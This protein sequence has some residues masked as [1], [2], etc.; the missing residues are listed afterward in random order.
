M[1]RLSSEERERLKKVLPFESHCTQVAG[2]GMHYFDEGQGSAVILLHGNPTWSFMFRA[3]I[4]GLRDSFRVIAPDCI[5]LGLSEHPREKRFRAIDRVTHLEEL[6]SSLSVGRFSL[7]MHDWG[8]SI[9]SMLAARDP[10]RVEKLVYLNTTLTE[11]ESL[12]EIIKQATT[13]VVGKIL[14]KY[15]TSFLRLLTEMG[16]A[17]RLSPEIRHAYLL[18]YPSAADRQAIWDF[19]ADIPFGSDH[20]SHGDLVLL[21]EKLPL[22]AAKPVQIV[23]GL[24]DPCFHREMLS[25]VA[26]HFP[27]ARVCEIPEAS[28]LVLEDA[29][30][31]ACL[32][33]R[34]F[35]CEPVAT[36]SAALVSEPSA[37]GIN[38]LYAAFLEQAAERPHSPAVIM[39]SA[40]GDRLSCT[41]TTFGEIDG[42]INQYQ[43]GLLSLGLEK[44]ERVLMLVSPGLD[45]S[46]LIFAVMARGAVPV[47][48]D[49]GVGKEKLIRCIEDCEA[50]AFAGSLPAFALRLLRRDLFHHF[51]FQVAAVD[52]PLPFAK[53]LSYLKRFSTAPLEAISNEGT[54]LI[55]Y[56]SGATGTPKGVLYTNEMIETQLRIFRED[57]GLEAG[58]VNMS[59]LPA[60]ALF[61]LGL[62]IASVFPSID[63][64]KPLSLDPGVI[65]ETI[66]QL[67]VAYSFGSPSLWNKICD[68]CLRTGTKLPSVKKLFMA[69][70][71]V[72]DEV[73]RKAMH[74]AGG[75]G[76]FTPYGATEALPVTLAPANELAKAIAVKAHD[77]SRGTIVGRPVSAVDAMIIED[78]DRAVPDIR[79]VR[80]CPA[81]VI[82][83][84]IVRGKNISPGYL[85]RPLAGAKSKITDGSSFWHRMGDLGY[86]DDAGNVYFCG[87]KIHAVRT[88][89]RTFY[90]IPCERVFNTHSKVQRSALIALDGGNRPGIVIEPRPEAWP[91]TDEA[92]R[93]FSAELRA[94]GAQ[95]P[96]T[97]PIEDFFFH[98]SF[99]VDGRHNV[100]IFREQLAEWA[101]NQR[102]KAGEP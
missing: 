26:R 82:G 42:L 12:P 95:D 15:S 55:A 34:N 100:K 96:V 92:R 64:K 90:P 21:G 63:Q 56:T 53:T 18:P 59:L 97:A 3:L 44:G 38:A 69:G 94:L 49:P 35:L 87:R 48:V 57:F 32:V 89:F 40:S 17:R 101:E 36:H 22:L 2:Y 27:G 86:R 37:D 9:G 102:R 14:T 24:K 31:K 8:G 66:Q 1:F 6:L 74:V 54:A 99:P 67:N 50:A 47:L 10:S 43:R 11:I 61:S 20:P 79:D 19:V 46:A 5:G 81:G 41:I 60:F 30:D 23:W 68:F 71:P 51:K 7:V 72:S 75:E 16:V 52:W 78:L 83:E 98:P 45:F 91:A 28:H 77:G 4:A 65:C 33:I 76:V 88:Q 39:P 58:S 85:H 80:E 70:A 93:R 13:P 62:G 29:P 25:K 73:L 84:I